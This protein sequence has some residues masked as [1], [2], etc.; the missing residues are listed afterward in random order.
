MSLRDEFE[1]QGN[2]LFRWRSFLPLV[3]L[4]P[5]LVHLATLDDDG[6]RDAGRK[7]WEFVCLGVSLLGLGVRGLTVGWTPPRTSGRNTQEQIAGCLNQTGLYSLVR[8]PLYV[9]NYLMWLGIALFCADA[10]LIL[11][12]HLAFWLYYERIMLA[13]EEFLRQ[14]FGLRFERWA[15]QTPAFFPRFSGWKSPGRAF[16]VRKVLRQEYTGLAGIVLL[17]SALILFQQYATLGRIE[18]ETP[19]VVIATIAS[20]GYVVLRTLKRRTRVLKPR[21]ATTPASG[22]V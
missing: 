3:L 17:F 9:G 19:W 6:V 7:T 20:V 5:V 22:M 21:P 14:Q 10:W 13:E 4:I 11:V 16:S 1:Q 2:W 15:A 12:F 8:H 18:F